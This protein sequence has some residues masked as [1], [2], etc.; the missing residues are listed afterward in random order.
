MKIFEMT[1]RLVDVES[2]SYNEGAVGE[3]IFELLSELAGRTNGRV[4]R[5]QVA[6]KRFNV[7]ACWGEP[8]V[9]LS[10]HM[11]TV[12]P[13]F[14]SREDDEFIYGRGATDAK[15]IIASMFAAGESL[16]VGGVRN[17][18]L[19]FVVGEEKDSAGAKVAAASPRGSQY[20]INGEPT[21]NRLALGSKGILRYDV[22]ARGK[23]AHSAYPELG[24]SAIEH[25]IDALQDIRRIPLPHDPVLGPGTVNIGTI[26]GGRAP[27][28]I[29][30][31]ARAEIL[32]RIVGPADS[33]R[34]A[35]TRAVAGRAEIKEVLH[36]PAIR[37]GGLDGFATT[38][39]AYTTDVPILA[40]SWGQPFLL[41]PGTIH[42]A[43]SPD[44]RVAKREL[45]E[46]AEIYA[47]LVKQLLSAD[48]AGAD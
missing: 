47:R 46:A 14:A 7:L 32:F 21:E 5:M 43:H 42:V 39:V 31:Y 24:E 3:L 45:V 37:L 27:N 22:I 6:E 44:E 8:V 1:R 48:G 36:I 11:D 18:A 29:P 34:D 2:I 23:M 15:G 13:F 16:A 25:M 30:D 40:E 4:E 35:I 12:P 19:L 20:V 38:V 17:F 9:T 33:I 10:T 28:V 26:S 41:G